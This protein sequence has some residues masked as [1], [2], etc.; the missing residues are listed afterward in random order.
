MFERMS[1]PVLACELR[2]ETV[3]LG[4]EAVFGPRESFRVDRDLTD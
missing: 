2:V 4:Q 1:E 3:E